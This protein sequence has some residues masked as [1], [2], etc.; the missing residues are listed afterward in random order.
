M[1]HIELNDL[2][3]P[4]FE[5]NQVLS[6]NHLNQLLGYL[7]TG[8]LA[9]RSHAI[10]TG[11]LGGAEAVF[12]KSGAKLTSVDLSC[13]AGITSQGHLAVIED[14]KLEYAAAY[15]DPYVAPP[16]DDN[17][18]GVK[19]YGPFWTGPA[20]N[21]EQ[22]NILELMTEAEI[23]ERPELDKTAA[24]NLFQTISTQQHVLLAYVENEQQDIKSCVLE[25]CNDRGQRM[26]VKVRKLAMRRMHIVP[27]NFKSPYADT[28]LNPLQM[29][30][31]LDYS[32]ENLPALY[33]T[34]FAHIVPEFAKALEAARL[35]FSAY[36][37]EG[38]ST[39]TAANVKKRLEDQLKLVANP[40]IQVFYDYLRDLVSTY[41][42]MIYGGLCLTSQPCT[43][44]SAFPRHLLISEMAQGGRS[45]LFRTA[46]HYFRGPPGPSGEESAIWQLRQTYHKIL[47]M[48]DQFR[49]N[50]VPK[51]DVRILPQDNISSSRNVVPYYYTITGSGGRKLRALWNH[52]ATKNRMLDDNNRMMNKTVFHYRDVN[53]SSEKNGFSFNIDDKRMVRV[54]GVL[55]QNS[56]TA[57]ARLEKL[58]KDF[59]L[60]FNIARVYTDD[61][62]PEDLQLAFDVSELDCSYQDCRTEFLFQ[63]RAIEVFLTKTLGK[64]SDWLLYLK[65]Q[66]APADG[67]IRALE[68]LAAEFDGDLSQ[69]D[70]NSFREHYIRLLA[71]CAEYHGN[72]TLFIQEIVDHPLFS[73]GLAQETDKEGT[74][75]NVL[76]ALA[77]C[78]L[79]K[80]VT[81]IFTSLN[82]N[83]II[84]L[85]A[86]YQAQFKAQL[87]VDQRQFKNFYKVHRGIEHIAGVT[88][89]GTFVLLITDGKVVGD[90]YLPYLC[91]C[92]CEGTMGPVR[93]DRIF[94]YYHE[95]DWRKE[96]PLCPYS[97]FEAAKAGLTVNNELLSKNGRRISVG[98]SRGEV[99][100]KEMDGGHFLVLS[101]GS[102][103]FG[104]LI[105]FSV[106]NKKE[107][108]SYPFWVT[109]KPPVLI[110]QDDHAVTVIKKSINI[111]I[112]END[113][114]PSQKY[115]IRISRHPKLGKA[116]IERATPPVIYYEPTTTRQGVDTLRYEI[117]ATLANGAELVSHAEV[118]I[119]IVEC[120]E[121]EPEPDVFTEGEISLPDGLIF[122]PELNSDRKVYYHFKMTGDVKDLAGPG[123]GYIYR[124]NT[125]SANPNRDGVGLTEEQ[126]KAKGLV[127]VFVPAF[128]KAGRHRFTYKAKT[129]TGGEIEK[130]F[131][132]VVFIFPDEIQA[133]VTG[134]NA[135]SQTVKFSYNYQPS[136]EPVKHLWHFGSGLAFSN[137]VK[138]PARKF[139]KGKTHKITLKVTPVGRD[140]CV[141]EATYT[142]NLFGT[143]ILPD[144][145]DDI[146]RR[147][148]IR[149]PDGPIVPPDDD[150]VVG[151]SPTTP[152]TPDVGPGIVIDP[153]TPEDF[154]RRLRVDVGEHLT[155]WDDTRDLLRLSMGNS[156]GRERYRNGEFDKPARL[157]AEKS[158][159]KSR[160]MMREF[161]ARDISVQPAG[162]AVE[163]TTMFVAR[164]FG[165]KGTVTEDAE[166][167]FDDAHNL[168]VFGRESG[169]E[170]SADFNKAMKKAIAAATDT[171]MK[172]RLS[173]LRKAAVAG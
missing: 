128:A 91:C 173:K 63:L 169:V 58:K 132:A 19:G 106:E 118:K 29:K 44:H 21:R 1:S 18:L 136:N 102:K 67:L 137:A 131:E 34:V 37:P 153:V 80:Q 150:V 15:N 60:A 156:E 81:A 50:A 8:D 49:P 171:E 142:L 172:E 22:R 165:R 10:G 43:D 33:G 61:G 97:M 99:Y 123:I 134:E 75:Y 113:L 17:S 145:I 77:F 160:N 138:P 32:S 168:I 71:E 84:N 98:G 35:E 93:S 86:K 26:L 11:W 125:S 4:I 12:T 76:V 30:R 130:S 129:A 16:K 92:P 117:T 55:G 73:V 101:P 155:A 126:L 148:I 41:N 14:C 36:F 5:A 163:E 114:L 13:G 100:L 135:S 115:E 78:E 9:T 141:H 53:S 112:M 149:D 6:S 124:S 88:F 157:A 170:Y 47:K 23:D 144:D 95:Q 42:Q 79:K 45:S 48:T 69:F 39:R 64:H 162:A 72:L 105:N 159:L 56:N 164:F 89:G 109:V 158:F 24:R 161:R 27:E 146:F 62:F 74:P 119:H 127:R 31:V 7:E 3:Y 25:D 66:P 111:P 151:P 57:F 133:K 46:R 59:G 54:E 65:A 143:I 107:G 51:N 2:Q 139:E 20:S 83:K 116:T 94:P 120:C 90:F 147:R 38:E 166:K 104:R 140:D 96:I 40:Q 52:K 85:V 152:I 70:K 108:V 68:K 28:E 103:A 87:E 110:A 154:D 167:A 82:P 121:D 122:C